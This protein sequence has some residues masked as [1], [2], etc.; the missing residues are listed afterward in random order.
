MLDGAD[1][2]LEEQLTAGYLGAAR[3]DFRTRETAQ[4]RFRE[5]L[6]GST[7]AATPAQRELLAQRALEHAMQG[8]AP[9]DEVVAL[10][11]HAHAGGEL[12]REATADGVAWAGSVARIAVLRR[13]RRRRGRDQRR[14]GGRA[15]P[16][17]GDRL[18]RD[19]DRA[20][21]LALPARRP[22]PPR[23]AISKADWSACR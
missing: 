4:T 16:R 6:A 20:R 3:L 5:L 23:S 7:D 15:P 8:N 17:L 2:V 1:P 21:R 14:L 12:L 9:H 13:A 10:I 18:R 11:R 19:V 22:R